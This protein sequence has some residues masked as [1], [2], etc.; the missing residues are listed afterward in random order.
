MFTYYQK[1][2]KKKK[3]KERKKEKEGELEHID[4]NLQPLYFLN[5]LVLHD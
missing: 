2:I 4:S 5:F 1:E 3:Q